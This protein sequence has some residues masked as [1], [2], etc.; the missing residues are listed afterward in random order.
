MMEMEADRMT[1]LVLTEDLTGPELGVVLE[2]R[3]QR[4][5]SNPGALFGEQ[6]RAALYLNH[7]YGRPV[8]GWRSEIE[9]LTMQDALDFYADHYA[10]N[11]AILI[12][13]GDVTPDDVRALAQEHY[14]GIPANPAITAR[15]R[16]AEPPHLAERRID[17]QD[18]RIAQPYVIRTYLAPE[19]DPGA[20][21]EAA[22]LV[23]LADLLGGN[24]ATSLMGKALEFETSSAV[25][26][27][28][29]Y[30]GLSLDD[31]SFGLVVVPAPGRTLAQA[32]ADMDAVIARFM[33][34]GPDAEAFARI[35]TQ[36]AASQIY[37]RDSLQSRA[38]RYGEALTSG[39]TVQDV[40][41][42]PDILQAVTQEDVMAA[43]DRIFDKRRAV[44]GFASAPDMTDEGVTQ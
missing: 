25:Y 34:E 29:F 10:P 26:T 2:E 6:R 33:E 28:A 13:A 31:S 14:A 32:E 43:A 38:R 24:S 35:K 4:T 7:P 41:D 20:Q 19:R 11:N 36:I 44:T 3:A 40:Q 27:A 12:V 39:L 30:D 22:A 37:S 42:W 5:D 21:A 18:P 9:S 15:T 16:P 17:F 23:Y 1:D 8:I